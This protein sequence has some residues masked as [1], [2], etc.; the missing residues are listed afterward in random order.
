MGEQLAELQ[1]PVTAQNHVG[2]EIR[3]IDLVNQLPTTTTWWQ[4]DT[5]AVQRDYR[6][7]PRLTTLEHLGDG[8]VLCAKAK[9]ASR[10]DAYSGE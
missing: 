2:F 1:N 8:G 9:T 10:V 7:N 3:G 4:H 5:F 6:R